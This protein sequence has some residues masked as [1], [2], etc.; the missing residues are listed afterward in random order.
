MEE[1]RQ[2][3]ERT[4]EEP[5]ALAILDTVFKNDDLFDLA[6]V[7]MY[8][9]HLAKEKVPSVGVGLFAGIDEVSVFFVLI[10]CF[11]RGGSRT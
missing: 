6:K 11:R 10:Q 7:Q 5:P 2:E 9:N 1:L 3:C 4:G 8:A